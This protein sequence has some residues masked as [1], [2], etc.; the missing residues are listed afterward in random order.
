MRNCFTSRL[1]ILAAPK[2]RAWPPNIHSPA[3]AL[4]PSTVDRLFGIA[5]I[6]A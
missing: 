5:D 3:S 4:S 1:A 2:V 6:S